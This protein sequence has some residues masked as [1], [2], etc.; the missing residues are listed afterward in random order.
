M[1]D[2]FKWWK[3]KHRRTMR[4]TGEHQ[5]AQCGPSKLCFRVPGG[6][7]Q[8][9]RIWQSL[10]LFLFC[11]LE[12]HC[13]LQYASSAQVEDPL[14]G[15]RNHGASWSRTWKIT[16]EAPEG[17]FLRSEI[18]CSTQLV[19]SLESSAE[20]HRCCA[21]A[22]ENT[23]PMW[24]S[25]VGVMVSPYCQLDQTFNQLQDTPPGVSL[26]TFPKESNWRGKTHTEF[27][28]YYLIAWDI[29]VKRKGRKS[30]Q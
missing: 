16:C 19:R 24:I 18:R 12:R 15:S 22:R 11:S 9:C 4:E 17:P 25:V 29:G 26:R 30:S 2:C 6:N 14:V 7:S 28:Y 27:G 21:V 5:E 13:Y 3:E 23:G 1:W 8:V 20:I 10:A